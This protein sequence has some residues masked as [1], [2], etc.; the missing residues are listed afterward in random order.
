MSEIES[1]TPIA[2]E[3]D[4]TIDEKDTSSVK[5]SPSNLQSTDDSS[6]RKSEYLYLK[7]T[8]IES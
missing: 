5:S 6:K 1:V 8:N 7:Y 4:D 3:L 2:I